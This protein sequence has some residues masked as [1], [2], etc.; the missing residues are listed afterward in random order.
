MK[1]G[2]SAPGLESPSDGIRYWVIV[3]RGQEEFRSVLEIAFSGRPSFTVIEDRRVAP[4][5]IRRA[6]DRR[7][8]DEGFLS[9]PFFVAERQQF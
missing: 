5:A 8:S 7:Q 3:R 4:R 2:N 6:E 1:S 9:E